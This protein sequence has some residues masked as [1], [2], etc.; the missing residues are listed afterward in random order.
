[1]VVLVYRMERKSC[2]VEECEG[3]ATVQQLR[4]YGERKKK[5]RRF[6][7]LGCVIRRAVLAVGK[8]YKKK[9]KRKKS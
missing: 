1:M 8:V 5:R 2:R 6:T 3:L 9:R 4:D 7:P